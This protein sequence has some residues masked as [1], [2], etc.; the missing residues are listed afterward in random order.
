[1]SVSPRLSLSAWLSVAVV[2]FAA[3]AVAASAVAE[4]RALCVFD[5]SGANGDI[6]ANMK[7]YQVAAAAWGATFTLKPYTNEAAAVEDFK[8]KQCHAML[9]TGTRSRPF[10]MQGS[11]VEGIGALPNYKLLK[12][13]VKLLS[14]E[15]SAAMNTQDEYENVGIFP[16][17]AIYLLVRDRNVDTIEEL[18]G[19]KIATFDFDEASKVMVREAGAAIS[20]ADVSTFAGM[21]NN[22]SVDA[23]YAPATAFVPLEL[24]KG[25]GSAGGVIRYPLAQMTMQLIVRTADFPAGF[26]QLSRSYAAEKVGDMIKAVEKAEKAIPEKHWVDISDTDKARYDQLFLDVRVRLRDEN[27]VY[28][29]TILSLMRRV[30][31]KEDEA[32]A[33]CADKRE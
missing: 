25:I 20:P 23:A 24:A 1:M 13:V 31:C 29:K 8:S 33:E 28:D 16:T 12:S 30:R 17:G 26:G 22:G 2:A 6:Y 4:E 19:K 14:S 11:T 27:K 5:P 3:V 21:F 9:V 7:D 15:K 18:A 10:N 32:R